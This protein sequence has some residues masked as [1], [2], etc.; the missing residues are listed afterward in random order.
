MWVLVVLGLPDLVHSL[1]DVFPDG[2]GD[3]VGVA[4]FHSR[5]SLFMPVRQIVGANTSANDP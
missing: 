3:S 1:T 5:K 4:A 2:V